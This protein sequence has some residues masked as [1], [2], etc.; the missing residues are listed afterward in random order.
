MGRLQGKVIIVTGAAAGL[1]KAIA[2]R[3][4]E[5]GAQVIITDLDVKN[6]VELA[7]QLNAHFIEQDVTNE[8]R[9][10]QIVD[11]IIA[12]YGRIDGL[13][14]NAGLSSLKGAADPENALWE[15][16]EKIFK[17]NMGG[18]FLGCKYVVK[19][20][21]KNNGTGA[22]INMSSIGSLVP[23]PFLTSYGASKAAVQHFSRSL[24]L[25][26]CEMGYAIRSNCIHPGQVYTPMYEDLI[27]RVAQ[28][29]NVSI[30]QA[31]ELFLAKIPM[32]KFQETIDIANAA[33]FL[34]SDEARY[35]TGSSLVVDGGMTL[36]N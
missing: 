11:E 4:H 1:G 15:D 13:V 36:T 19:A 28:E 27:Q 23:T 20:M 35:I 30:E 18:V 34:L 6:G 16:W 31:T 3:I 2:Q 7:Q 12:K 14:N 24:A 21:A 29:H 22:I 33:L 8:E 17:V 9:W 5:E 26:C 10:A 25:H 32:K